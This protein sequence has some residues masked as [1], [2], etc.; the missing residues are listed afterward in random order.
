MALH[1][2]WVDVKSGEPV[3]DKSRAGLRISSPESPLK[4]QYI[5][6]HGGYNTGSSTSL[7]QT[8][9]SRKNVRRSSIGFASSLPSSSF[10]SSSLSKRMVKFN[11]LPRFDWNLR[12]CRASTILGP[13]LFLLSVVVSL[14]EEKTLSQGTAEAWMGRISMASLNSVGNLYSFS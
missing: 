10:I 2:G 1:I 8:Y 9:R 12:S 13:K 5:P 3:D 7:I 14:L 11:G 6:T 4:H